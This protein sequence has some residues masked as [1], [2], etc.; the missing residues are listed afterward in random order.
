MRRSGIAALA[1]TSAVLLA[2][3][4][5]SQ[6]KLEA[7]DHASSPQHL[8]SLLAVQEAP[9]RA[10]SAYTQRLGRLHTHPRFVQVGRGGA[11]RPIAV[12]KPSF[13]ADTGELGQP[14]WAPAAGYVY[15]E[16]LPPAAWGDNFDG[17]NFHEPFQGSQPTFRDGAYWRGVVGESEYPI[18]FPEDEVDPFPSFMHVHCF[19]LSRSASTVPSLPLFLPAC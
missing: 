17:K 3:A 15:D 5:V 4:L 16:D 1:V 8:Q 7:A 18:E 6:T 10:Y 2:L 14:A 9:A 13:L 11:S 12:L 19:C